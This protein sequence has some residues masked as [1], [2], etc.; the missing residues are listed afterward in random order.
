MK[1][2]GIAL[3][4]TLLFCAVLFAIFRAFG[5][6]DQVAAPLASAALPL[7]TFFHDKVD[8]A[9]TKG[10]SEISPGIV[11]VKAFSIRWPIMLCYTCLIT[12]GLIEVANFIYL[13]PVRFLGLG[14]K[15]SSMQE[16]GM[17]ALLGMPITCW[18]V[19]LLGRWVGIRN[20]KA[21][22]WILPVGFAISRIVE[23]IL[24]YFRAPGFKQTLLG[25]YQ[26]KLVAA[27]AVSILAFIIACGLLGVWRGNRIRFGAYFNSLLKQVSA[28]TRET[29]LAMTFDEAKASKAHQ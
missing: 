6:M 24:L 11:P 27:A 8:K 28:T 14:N 29:L 13:I 9:F 21:G 1:S 23:S 22:Y 16:V 25:M 19:F 15:F 4:I 17:A 2:L 5:V 7:I 18:G 3:A 10:T 26:S 12:L 20:G